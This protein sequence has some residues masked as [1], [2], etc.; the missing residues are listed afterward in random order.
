MSPLPLRAHHVICALGYE[1]HGYSDAFTANMTR[2]VTEGLR[3]PGG[4]AV[5]IEIVAAADAIC[6]PCPERRGE[7]CAKQAQIA[8]LDARHGAALGLRAGD[9]LSWAE[10]KARVAERVA[11]EDLEQIC[12][13]CAW[14]GLGL[15]AAAVARL[16]EG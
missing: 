15:C 5:Q 3:A 12:D 4:D 2:I 13:G 7:L 6:A 14:L 10:A 1:G 16:R 8:G 11:P 9:R